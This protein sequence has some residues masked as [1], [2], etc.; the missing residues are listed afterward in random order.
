MKS[1]LAL[2]QKERDSVWLQCVQEEMVTAHN[3]GSSELINK[4]LLW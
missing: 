3:R 2:I 4:D 1:L